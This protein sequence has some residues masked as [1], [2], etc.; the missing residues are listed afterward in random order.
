[1]KNIIIF[2]SNEQREFVRLLEE[3]LIN[4]SSDECTL[5]AEAWCD[6]L[7][8]V[9]HYTLEDLF[10]FKRTRDY[11]VIVC[12][13]D[14]AVIRRGSFFE[15]P[16]DNILFELGYALA[17]FG[18]ANVMVVALDNV[19]LPSDMQG[20]TV[21]RE[22]TVP[23][24]EA[25]ANRTA[26]KVIEQ[27]RKAVQTGNPQPI[28]WENYFNDLNELIGRIKRSEALG[29][30]PADLVIGIPGN[31]SPAVIVANGIRSELPV[32]Y[33]NP[34]RRNGKSHF[35]RSDKQ[36]GWCGNDYLV[37]KIAESNVDAILIVDNISRRAHTVLEARKYLEDGLSK[38]VQRQIVVKTAV[39]YMT[40]E[41]E[42][43]E[44]AS[45]VDYIGRT[46]DVRGR[47]LELTG[48]F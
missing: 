39:V 13:P 34:H 5:N 9:G 30:F 42:L 32:A 22:R 28:R 1:M 35:E 23:E 20:V 7:F 6:G 45:M 38:R 16:R 36:S 11:A 17:A 10:R 43:Q 8:Q 18:L 15:E 2:S 41:L 48:G 44:S 46:L 25:A 31:F 12:S 47:R 40:D 3:K 27:I 29:G 21:I 33:L 37:E 26:I 19:I 14:D 4:G 24:T